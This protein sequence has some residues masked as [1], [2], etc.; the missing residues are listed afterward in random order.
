LIRC[1]SL[2][3]Q[4]RAFRHGFFVVHL[5][6]NRVFLRFRK[7]RQP[8]AEC[9]QC[10]RNSEPQFNEAEFPVH[11]HYPVP[12]P[13]ARLDRSH[14]FGVPRVATV[15]RRAAFEV[16]SSPLRSSS[17]STAHT[18]ADLVAK[19]RLNA[20]TTHLSGAIGDGRKLAS[21]ERIKQGMMRATEI[22]G[23]DPG[24]AR[25]LSSAGG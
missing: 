1:K 3:L 10:T 23:S 8:Y 18:P 21:Q 9:T 19:V 7:A 5:L 14:R 22:P 15:I 13:A 16:C 17:C 24:S 20:I 6:E 25:V 11:H 12:L 4:L 2:I